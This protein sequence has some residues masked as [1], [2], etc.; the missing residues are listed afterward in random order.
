[1]MA[2]GSK[3]PALGRI[4]TVDKSDSTASP[5]VVAQL[6][7]VIQERKRLRPAGS[8]TTRLLEGGVAAIGAKIREEA[9]EV[10]EAAGEPEPGGHGH[11]VY[12]AADVMYHLLVLLAARDVDWTEV[13]AELARRFGISGLAEK[14]TRRVKS[15][16]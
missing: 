10:A 2:T 7:T 11:L 1:M 15:E 12:E 14:A 9:D 4:G 3:L 8:Y 13:E 6:M 16:E 5:S